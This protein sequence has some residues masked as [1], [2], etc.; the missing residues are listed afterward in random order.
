MYIVPR[1][2]FRPW[3]YTA[4]GTSQLLVSPA[5][6]EVCG[7][8]VLPIEEHFNSITLDDIADIYS[9]VCYDK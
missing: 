9:Q 5:T 3:Q 2:A 7:V 1:K 6:A 8:I 4:E